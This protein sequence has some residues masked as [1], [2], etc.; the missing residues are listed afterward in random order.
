MSVPKNIKDDAGQKEIDELLE[1]IKYELLKQ[2]TTASQDMQKKLEAY[3]EQFD[4]EDAYQRRLLD[5]G[6]ITDDEYADWRKRKMLV[7]SRWRQMRDVLAQ[8]ATNTDTIALSIIKGHMPSAYAIGHNYG[9]YMIESG[10]GID[11]SYTLYDRQTVE[12]LVRENPKL[13]PDPSPRGKTAK[14]LREN[15]DLIWNKDH[16][17]GQIV[18]GIVQGEPLHDI[19]KRMQNVTDMDN[20]AANRNAATMMTSAH[21][22]GRVDSFKRAESMGIQLKKKWLATLDGHTRHAHKLLDGQEQDTDKP[23][24][25]ELGNIMFPGD[26]NANPRNVWNCRCT[27]ISQLKGFERD[28]SDL[29]L[30][31]DDNLKG[32]SYEEWKYQHAK[33]VIP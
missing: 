11:T 18:Q 25:S 7:G 24:K 30:R 32:Q 20:R 13:M 23:F 3:L 4:I 9:T 5:A 21:N 10:L 27:L 8:D 2:Y 6:K 1:R 15:K 31:H 22:G 29:S 17:Q 12:R 19:A 33:A 14:K 26:P 28:T 16:I